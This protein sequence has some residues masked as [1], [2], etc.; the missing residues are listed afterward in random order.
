MLLAYRY[1]QELGLLGAVSMVALLLGAPVPTLQAPHPPEERLMHVTLEAPPPPAPEIKPVAPSV[2]PP[3]PKSAAPAPLPTLAKPQPPKP[4]PPKPVPRRT[5][6]AAPAQSPTPVAESS[7]TA[8][9]TDAAPSPPSAA[10]PSAQGEPA[11]STATAQGSKAGTPHSH[12][13]SPEAAFIAALKEMVEA[14]KRYPTSKE[15]RLQRPM[16]EVQVWFELARD[17]T[18]LD[19][20]VEVSAASMI[21]DRAAVA[22]VRQCPFPPIPAELW[23]SESRHRFYVSLSFNPG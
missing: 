19:S 4:A 18:I 11:T 10:I 22:T 1:R 21:L 16:G 2:A 3:P 20:G 14:N 5:V 7:A 6:E 15:A 12:N 17:G 13:Q 23:A 9:L 8:P